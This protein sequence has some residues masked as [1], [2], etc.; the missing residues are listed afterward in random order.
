VKFKRHEPLNLS[1][2]SI[3]APADNDLDLPAHELPSRPAEMELAPSPPLSPPPARAETAPETPRTPVLV[4]DAPREQPSAGA[5][6]ART[7]NWLIYGAAGLASLLWGALA[8]FAMGFQWPAGSIEFQPFQLGVFGVL[9]IAPI[10]F[11]WVLAFGVRQGVRLAAEVRRTK[12]LAD[13]MLQPAA[14][15]AAKSGSA[16]EDV[17]AQIEAATQAATEARAEL[18][19][20]REALAEETARLSEAAAQSARTAHSLHET[21]G[22]ERVELTAL[23]ARLDEQAVAV[24]DAVTRQARM[25]SE[26]SDLAQTQIG[27]AEAGLAARAADLAAAAGEATDAA[28]VASEDLARQTARLEAAGVAVSDQVSAVED[29]LSQQRA[30]LVTAAHGLR[31]D[32]EEF[33]VRLESQRAQVQEMLT[34]A[35]GAVGDLTEIA[36]ESTA[37]VREAAVAAKQGFIELT[38]TAKAERDLIAAAALQSVG[39]V[40]EA[41]RFEREQLEAGVRDGVAAMAEAAADAHKL[42]AAQSET[43]RLKIEQL[44]EAAFEAGQKSETAYQARLAD[45]QALIARSA[46]LV[47]EAAA[48]SSARLERA[49]EDAR[50]TFTELDKVIAEFETRASR[51]PDEAQARAEELKAAIGQGFEGLMESARRAAE[52]TQAI[53]AAFQ[54]RVRRNYEMLSEAVRLMGV[55]S[56]PAAASAQRALNSPRPAEPSP[57][58][59]PMPEPRRAP[60]SPSQSETSA[61]NLRLRLKLAPTTADEEISQVF[62]APSPAP[63]RE[64]AREP[65]GLSWQDLLGSMDDAPIEDDQL[66]DRIIGEV[67]ALGA[68]LPALLPAQRIEEI[69]AVLEAGDVAGARLVIKRLAPAAVRRLSRRV[70]AE[71]PLRGHA[72]R[73][74]RRY[75]S[76]LNEAL[77]NGKGGPAFSTLLNTDGGRAFLLFDAA[78]GDLP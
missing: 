48:A 65:D 51:L 49:V 71:R 62:D 36:S 1:M 11:I 20:L 21:L 61:S 67:E 43:A 22:G 19:Q 41:A 2:A 27:E 59:E 72:D 76:A 54:E 52:E 38:E 66:A 77:Q 24:V 42:A 70:L 55:V 3:E 68:D 23:S 31:A 50:Q 32:H 9:A 10:G 64:P 69:A 78:I 5:P 13:E 8:V 26:A 34:E 18:L 44:S 4:D 33:S 25:V 7:A 14:A 47:D 37:S 46:D 39:A 29:V 57:P 53:D 73:F 15:A 45:A 60:V 40:S 58:R 63:V 74:I 12:V 17:R 6:A 75:E 35:R 56:S 28:R 30:G 16:I